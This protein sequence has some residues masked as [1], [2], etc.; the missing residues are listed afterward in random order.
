MYCGRIM[1]TTQQS[2]GT[3][4]V[5]VRVNIAGMKHHDKEQVGEERVYFGL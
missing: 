2:L 3:V 4:T 1:T 5:R